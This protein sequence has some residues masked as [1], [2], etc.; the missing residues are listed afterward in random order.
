M[1]KFNK[2]LSGFAVGL[3]IFLG[4]AAVPPPP[5]R[6]RAGSN[7]TVTTN[8]PSDFTIASSG[9][10]STNGGT[11]T[12]IAFTP[13]AG[14]SISGSPI[15]SSGT[16][17]LS[18]PGLILTNGNSGVVTFSNNVTVDAAHTLTANGGITA[19]SLNAG[20]GDVFGNRFF[21]L[22]STSQAYSGH[23]GGLTNLKAS[24][25]CSGT[26]PIAR[27]NTLQNTFPSALTNNEN[28]NKDKPP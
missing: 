11:V 21:A 5:I 26:I 10:G 19:G 18:A 3:L 20:A 28:P 14:L 1:S 17:A 8:N 25:L 9:G 2:L 6:I 7:V 15:T 24:N 4:I 23:G 16:L 22:I 27:Q 13:P 12:S